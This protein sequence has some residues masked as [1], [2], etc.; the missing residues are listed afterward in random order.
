MNA[1]PIHGNPQHC[2]LNAVPG[3]G[4]GNETMSLR[5]V[6][7]VAMDNDGKKDPDIDE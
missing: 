1:Q 4:H 5:R 2:F 7:D 3:T 6:W